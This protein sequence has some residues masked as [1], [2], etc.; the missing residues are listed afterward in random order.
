M[1]EMLQTQINVQNC[2]F[3]R[4]QNDT[5]VHKLL[6]LFKGGAPI[7]PRVRLSKK[8][9]G[10]KAKADLE[11]I[12]VSF[13]RIDWYQLL[14]TLDSSGQYLLSCENGR[15]IELQSDDLELSYDPAEGF[16]AA[17]KNGIIVFVDGK[18]DG[19]LITLGL[20][21]DLARN[22]QQLRKERGY[23]TTD[24]LDTAYIADLNEEEIAQLLPLT[25]ELKYLVRVNRIVI[26][27]SREQGI[28]YKIIEL[29]G[30]KLY[31]SV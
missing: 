13:E 23:D 17:E 8:K 25:E 7:L 3:I 12:L 14:R 26:S 31:L 2:I 24:I 15:K 11:K 27:S 10:Q 30:R 28:D 1:S 19:R 4:Y 22:L 9:I 5:D 20:M 21:R 18:R 6:S 16:A 29:E